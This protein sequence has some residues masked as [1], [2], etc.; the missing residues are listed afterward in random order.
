[1]L[2]QVHSKTV[3]LEELELQFKELKE[4]FLYNEGVLQERDDEI[5]ALESQLHR[6]TESHTTVRKLLQE[7]EEE[8]SVVQSQ[9]QVEQDRCVASFHQA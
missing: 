2:M 9:L 3:A 4:D 6:A 8:C 1:M 7:R 5:R